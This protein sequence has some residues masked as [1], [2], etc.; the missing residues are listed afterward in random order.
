MRYHNIVRRGFL[1]K[2][3][4]LT[5]YI[6]SLFFLPQKQIN[7]NFFY[8]EYLNGLKSKYNNQDIIGIIEIDNTNIN[9]IIVRGDD[10]KYYLTH[11]LNN[12]YNN[13]GTVFMD[14]RN[15]I[16]DRKKII[17]GHNIEVGNAP[18]KQLEKFLEKDFFEKRNNIYL[19]TKS[20]RK[21][22]TVF[23]VMIVDSNSNHMQL[24]Y[25]N[26]QEYLEF[27]KNNS[28]YESNI[29]LNK[30]NIII[31]QTCN[32]KPKNTYILVIAKEEK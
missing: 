4:I 14:Y 7:R 25:E 32:F 1:I 17:F 6:I 10:N 9:E 26:W 3:G 30:D 20:G 28:I 12:K 21:I 8:E 23:S 29:E 19:T 16:S 2:L 11:D 13:L 27:L 31:L 15:D 24:E 22:Y 18:F 5:F